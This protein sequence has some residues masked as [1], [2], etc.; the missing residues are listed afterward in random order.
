MYNVCTYYICTR[1]SDGHSVRGPKTAA[2]LGCHRGRSVDCRAEPGLSKA[3][4]G[5]NGHLHWGR[6]AGDRLGPWKSVPETSESGLSRASY[7][8]RY[9]VPH[10]K[11]I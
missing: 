8:R 5:A 4:N 9:Y 2:L 3:A 1:D 11:A 7:I 6:D 10:T